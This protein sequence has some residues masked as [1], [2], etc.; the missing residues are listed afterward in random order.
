MSGLGL[1]YDRHWFLK[2]SF[3]SRS[4]IVA[5]ENVTS[6]QY[7]NSDHYLNVYELVGGIEVSVGNGNPSAVEDSLIRAAQAFRKSEVGKGYDH[8]MLFL[9][10]DKAKDWVMDIVNRAFAG[11]YMG[12][13]RN[14]NFYTQDVLDIL[15]I[16]YNSSFN[17][18]FNELIE[19]KRVGLNG[20]IFISYDQYKE[21]RAYAKESS[22]HLN[23]HVND[24]GDW[25]CDYC[26]N[27]AD[28]QEGISPTAVPCFKK[29]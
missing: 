28:S 29:G 9:N 10:E 14:E 23:Y 13:Y 25:F 19:E 7:G 4:Y 16:S 12:Q 1:T 22:G 8:N 18:I 17:K 2:I 5:W 15:G 11:E 26:G 6:V 24:Y 21:N 3:D 20:N 27:N